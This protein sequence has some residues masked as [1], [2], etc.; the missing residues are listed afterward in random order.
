VNRC[1]DAHPKRNKFFAA[2]MIFAAVGVSLF[3]SYYCMKVDTEK[4]KE[5]QETLFVRYLASRNRFLYFS[6]E[7]MMYEND[8]DI[9]TQAAAH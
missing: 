1:R 3:S 5:N 9:L 8:T 4:L 7:I 6:Y 2:K